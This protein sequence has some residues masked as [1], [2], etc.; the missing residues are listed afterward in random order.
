MTVLCAHA[1]IT[2]SATPSLDVILSVS[3]T[4]NVH[5]VWHVNPIDVLTHVLMPVVRILSVML[6][7]AVPDV[8]ALNTSKA[9]H[10]TDAM[11]N[12]QLTMTVHHIRPATSFRVS[13]PV[14]EPVV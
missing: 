7:K 14:R 11:L 5:S 4:P 3:K 2:I 10:N 1:L 8:P 9:T 12:A 6:F 13:T